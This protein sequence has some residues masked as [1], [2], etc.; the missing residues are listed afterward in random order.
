MA[1]TFDPL[2]EHSIEIDATPAQVWALITDIP[3]MSKWSPQVVSSKVSGGVVRDGAKFRNLNK[4]G[5]LRWPTNGKVVRYTAQ[6]EFA[7]RIAENGVV[8][9]FTLEPN[10]AGGTTLTERRETPDGISKVSLV[11]T[12]FV[13]GGQ[14]DFT[15]RLNAGMQQTLERVKA[16]AESA[17]AA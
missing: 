5:L 7:F 8:W 10:A 15:A 13:L 17:A 1:D 4:Q 11:L 14:K 9:S 2:L 16:D 3:R 12:K 6:Q